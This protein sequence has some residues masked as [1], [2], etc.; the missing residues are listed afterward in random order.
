[1]DG[2]QLDEKIFI[3]LTSLPVNS[4]LKP[5]KAFISRM[6]TPVAVLLPANSSSLSYAIERRAK[7]ASMLVRRL[8]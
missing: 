3:C 7:L 2:S 5:L 8:S 4:A 1:M 6:E